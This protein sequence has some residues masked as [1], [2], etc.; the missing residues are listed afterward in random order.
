MSIDHWTNQEIHEHGFWAA[1]QCL[2]KEQQTIDRIE[3]TLSAQGFQRAEDDARLWTR[4]KKKLVLCL[5]D[6]VR[7]ASRDYETDTPY[8]FDR[9]TLIITDNYFSCP[10]TFQVLTLPVSFFSIYYNKN[11][12]R[13]QPDR[14]FC[15]SINRLDHRRFKLMLE[16]A[17]RAHLPQGYINFNCQTLA[18]RQRIPSDPKPTIESLQNNFALCFDQM[19]SE[20]TE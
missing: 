12:A 13:W 18:S 16:L 20:E 14:A 15:F 8:L 5:V 2:L 6:D 11:S 7:S 17:K 1:T 9:D 4:G 10:V 19:S 3:S